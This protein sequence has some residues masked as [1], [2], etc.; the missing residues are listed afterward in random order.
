MMA[1]RWQLD[2]GVALNAFPVSSL[3]LI[4]PAPHPATTLLMSLQVKVYTL[5]VY[6]LVVS[7]SSAWTCDCVILLSSCP[8]SLK[9][10][11]Y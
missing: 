1:A 6:T 7:L 10:Y 11:E 2:A 5:V 9:Q 8:C 4:D 3:A